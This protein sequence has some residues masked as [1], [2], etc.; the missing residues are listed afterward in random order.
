MIEPRFTLLGLA[1]LLLA[2][3]QALP[4]TPALKSNVTVVEVDVVV[5]DKSGAPVRGLS[6]D[7]FEIAEDGTPVEIVSFSAIDLPETP[8]ERVILPTNRSGSA[9]ASNATAFTRASS[10]SIRTTW[11]SARRSSWS[12][13]AGTRRRRS[14]VERRRWW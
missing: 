11:R 8:R 1:V 7:D 13:S 2:P 3:Q 5:T 12:T 4:P 14:P 9:F 6:R 10:R